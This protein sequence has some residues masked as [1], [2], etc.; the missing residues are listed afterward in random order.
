MKFTNNHNLPESFVNFVRADK[1]SRGDADISVTQLID[2]PRV[3]L[4][5]NDKAD[6]M[7]TDVSDRV[8]SLF[9]TAVH[10]IL[11]STNASHAV[12]MEERLFMEVDG[13]KLSWRY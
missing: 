11:E 13:W 9:G 1:Y 4:L 7:E 2:S 3:R 10:H 12:T 5:R 8:W 6:E